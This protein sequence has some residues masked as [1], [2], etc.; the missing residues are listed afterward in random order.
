MNRLN[1]L[2]TL[3]INPSEKRNPSPTGE[4]PIRG[5][6]EIRLQ[7]PFLPMASGSLHAA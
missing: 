4:K 3:R 2:P 6:P 5:L 7:R 1:Q